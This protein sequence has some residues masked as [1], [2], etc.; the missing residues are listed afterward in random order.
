[1]PALNVWGPRTEAKLKGAGIPSSFSPWARTSTDPQPSAFYNHG[2]RGLACWPCC[3][4]PHCFLRQQK[5]GREVLMLI[6]TPREAWLSPC[7]SATSCSFPADPWIAEPRPSKRWALWPW[8]KLMSGLR[9]CW[10]MS[11]IISVNTE[12]FVIHTHFSFNSHS[13]SEEIFSV[14]NS[15]EFLLCGIMGLSWG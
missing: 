13:C 14:H 2:V 9:F 5:Y 15:L 1:M 12:I 10:W 8:T 4:T 11:L 6:C 7:C 3:S